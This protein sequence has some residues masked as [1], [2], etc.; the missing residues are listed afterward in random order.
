MF[1]LYD[2]TTGRINQ[3]QSGP[4]CPNAETGSLDIGDSYQSDL[5]STHYVKDGAIALRP[6][7]PG[8]PLSGRAPV[9]IDLKFFER[10]AVLTVVNEAGDSLSVAA[11]TEDSLTLTDPG[12]YRIHLVQPFPHHTV[13]SVLDLS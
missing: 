9:V 10:A 6:A 3:F 11:E 8:L 4:D 7:Y 5:Q 13:A 2:K 12:R 1:A